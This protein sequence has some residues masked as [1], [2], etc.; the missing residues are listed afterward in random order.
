MKIL[1]TGANGFL[2]SWLIK[3]LKDDGQEVSVLLRNQEEFSHFLKQGYRVFRG[4]VTN[5][6]SLVE[7]MRGQQQAYHLAGLVAYNKSQRASMFRVNVEGT[8]NVFQVASQHQVEKVLLVSSVV[9]VGATLK[10]E[11]LNENSPYE[12]AHLNLGYHESKR[13]A[14][15]IV[16]RYVQEKKINGVIVNPST[17][18]GA[19]D[20]AKDTR[21]TQL[22]VARGD[23][24][25]YPPGGVS[26]VAVEDVIDGMLR[27]MQFG[28]SGERYILAGENLTLKAVFDSISEFAGAKEVAIPLPGWS[29]DILA[30]I[31]RSLAKIGLKGPLPSE[32]AMVA[33]MFH[34][35]DSSKARQ[36]LGFSTRPAKQA[37]ENSVHWMLQ[38]GLLRK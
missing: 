13:E 29:L 15:K 37:I 30:G 28:R 24:L 19:G 9:A 27:A 18:Y 1:V 12:L 23:M 14:E 38:Q 20:A 3:K 25:F 36:E 6:D 7:A 4:D 5:P 26:V 16:R 17:V 31:D 2:G 32:R 22:K 21:S 11:I 8:E 10:A 35:Y 34:W 33:R